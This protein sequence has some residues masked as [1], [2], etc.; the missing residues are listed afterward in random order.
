MRSAALRFAKKRSPPHVRRRQVACGKRRELAA[1]QRFRRGLRNSNFHK[2]VWKGRRASGILSDAAC[3]R[4]DRGVRFRWSLNPRLSSGI[5]PRCGGLVYLPLVGHK[6]EL[7]AREG[8]E[9]RRALRAGKVVADAK[10]VAFEFVDRGEGLALVWP[11]RAGD[12]DALGLRRGMERVGAPV[13]FVA[14][15]DFMLPVVQFETDA[16]HNCGGQGPG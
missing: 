2:Q 1:L 16:L 8:L 15:E 3:F 13:G 10:R 5:A 11:F 12:G 7:R 6:L 4:P 9:L 14:D